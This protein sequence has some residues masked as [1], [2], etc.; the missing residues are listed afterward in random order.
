MKLGG[1][2]ETLVFNRT[3]RIACLGS[4]TC[5]DNLWAGRIARVPEV[6]ENSTTCYQV[7]FE[8]AEKSLW[9]LWTSNRCSLVYGCNIDTLAKVRSSDNSLQNCSCR[10]ER[11]SL[12]INKYV[13][14]LPV[15]RYIA[16]LGTVWRDFSPGRQIRPRVN[17]RC[18]WVF[19]MKLATILHACLKGADPRRRSK[20]QARIA[21]PGATV[22]VRLENVTRKVVI[23]IIASA[24]S[25][26]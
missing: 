2:D 3:A 19:H 4:V 24:I 9:F 15:V 25:Q 20:L 6:T 7:L 10:I 14:T 23:A 22:E 13:R 8:T 26:G 21:F 11:W 5:V 16:I 12:M 1:R 18:R 17:R